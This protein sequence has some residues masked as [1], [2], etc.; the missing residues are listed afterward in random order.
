METYEDLDE[1][2]DEEGPWDE[3]ERYQV[4]DPMESHESFTIMEDFVDELPEGEGC[5]ALGRALRLPRPFRCFKDTLVDFP[6]LRER[7]FKYHDAKMLEYAQAWLDENL[8][9]AELTP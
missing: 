6:D 4:I 8:P 7:W 3:S 2:S 1:D 5:R 9:G